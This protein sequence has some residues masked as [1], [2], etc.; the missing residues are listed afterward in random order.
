MPAAF[1]RFNATVRTPESGT[2]SQIA[3]S[4]DEEVAGKDDLQTCE[5][6]KKL[7]RSSRD[8]S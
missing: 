1:C 8:P 2:G 7:L 4:E 6:V 3:G 5:W